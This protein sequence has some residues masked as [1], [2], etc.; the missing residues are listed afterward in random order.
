MPDRRQ[1]KT[2][3]G[4]SLREICQHLDGLCRRLQVLSQKTSSAQVLAYAKQVIR[5][6][7]INALPASLRTQVIEETSR[8]LY[9]PSLDGSSL[10]SGPAP[11]YLLALLLNHDIKQLKVNLCCYYGCSHQTSLLKLLASEGTGLESLELARSALLR[12]DCRLLRSALLNM[13]NLLSLTLRNIANDAV[14][15]VIGKTCPKL[16]HLDI[17]CSKQVTDAGLK[18]LLL[19]VELK[20]KATIT[21][22]QEPPNSWF[23]LKTLMMNRLKTKPGARSRKKDKENVLLEYYENRN[24]ICDTLKVLN[25]ANTTV[26]CSGVILA[27]VYISNLESLAE[28]NHMGSVVERMNKGFIEFEAPLALTQARST[29]TTLERLELL[30]QACPRVETLHIFEP[31]HPPKALR[32]FPCVTSL[33]IHSI[34]VENGWIN[35]F[36]EYLRTDGT[37]FKELNLHVAQRNHVLT[38]DLKKIFSSCPNLRKL[39]IDGSIVVWSAGPDPPPLKYLKKVRLG[40]KVTALVIIKILSLVPELTTLHIHSCSDLTNEHLE[41]LLTTPLWPQSYEETGRTENS[42][43]QNLSCFYIYEAS[44][45]SAPTVLN[46]FYNCKRLRRIGNLN[47]WGL[48]CDGINMLRKTLAHANL[49]VDLCPGSHWFWSNCIQ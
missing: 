39:M 11:L 29:K 12:L 23:K 37:N 4:L 26:T 43:V 49:D 8:M 36:Y 32:L 13:E 28:Y 33:S 19:E 42:L 18:Q 45:V 15:Q 2:L 5:P 40:H 9:G 41:K 38:I 30:A 14:L 24:S 7:Y 35:G 1:P 34:P 48:D 20:D 22:T 21:S 25:I 10:I 27:L 16:V 44:R 31:N 46:I 47:N 6:Y 17:A 3:E